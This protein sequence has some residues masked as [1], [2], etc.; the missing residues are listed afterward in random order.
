MAFLKPVKTAW[1]LLPSHRAGKSL[2]I[3]DRNNNSSACLFENKALLQPPLSPLRAR[4]IPSGQAGRR[5][6][7]E[8][9]PHGLDAR[10]A[11]GAPRPRPSSPPA[12]VSGPGHLPLEPYRRGWDQAT[13]PPSKAQQ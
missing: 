5:V 11:W 7:S 3:I 13:L 12:S 9:S 4:H 6:V 2:A 1:D 10:T 8:A